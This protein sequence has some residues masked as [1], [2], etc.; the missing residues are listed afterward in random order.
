MEATIRI[1]ADELDNS[2]VEHIKK[3]FPHHELQISV[4]PMDET[5]YI[6]S[7]PAFAAELRERIK[8]I[9]SGEPLIQVLPNDLL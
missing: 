1:N 6:L 2:F 7:Q 8:S 4:Q 9:E 5:D 3:M